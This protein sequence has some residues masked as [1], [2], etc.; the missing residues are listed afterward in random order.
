MRHVI[1]SAVAVATVV[2]GAAPVLAQKAP[3]ADVVAKFSGNWKINP[4]LSPS[5]KGSGKSGPGRGGGTAYAIVRYSAQ[6]GGRGGGT[7]QSPSS[8]ADLTPAELAERKAIMQIEQIAPAITIKATPET[9]SFVDQRG[10][11]ACTTNDKGIKL[12]TFGS[13]ITMKCKWDKEQLRQE[14][15]A[16]HSKLTRTWEVDSND[17]LVLRVRVEGISQSAGAA[18]AVFDRS[19]S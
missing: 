11:L 7:D 6:R 3:A 17:H 18:T 8:A 12:D 19:S 14:F 1:L 5:I 10:E 4:S 9:V 16:T 2:A 15:S 13:P